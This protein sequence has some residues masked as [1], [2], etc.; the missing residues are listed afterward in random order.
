M[1]EKKSVDGKLN[2]Y[3]ISGMHCAMC[4]KSV[5]NA[6]KKVNGVLQVE[7]NLG[8]ETAYVN[9]SGLS[10]VSSIKNAIEDAGY[11]LI[12]DEI[13]MNIQGMHCAM[14]VKSIEQALTALEGV[15]NVDIDLTA[16]T[17]RIKY[18]SESITISEIKEAVAKAGYKVSGISGETDPAQERKEKRALQKT[19]G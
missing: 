4:V 1:N 8:T 2:S 3:K 10:D 11:G 14:C 7:V 18:L 19:M 9:S 17:A 15:F 16:E 5:E 12:T 13:T 6:I